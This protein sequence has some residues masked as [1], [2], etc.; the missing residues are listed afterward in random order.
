MLLRYKDYVAMRQ[1][2]AA[3]AP[4]EACGLVAGQAG[5]SRGVFPIKNILHS[6]LAY[7]MAPAEQVR[8]LTRMDANGETLLAIYHS[9]PEGAPLPS[10]RDV[11][12]AAYDVIY[13]IWARVGATWVVRGFRLRGHA[14]EVPV[15]LI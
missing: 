2:V 6:P 9:H 8:A 5:E 14:Q 15:R 12:E 13:L 3:E 7:R 10:R 1:H 11:A 4:L